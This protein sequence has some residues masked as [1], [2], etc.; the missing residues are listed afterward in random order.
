MKAVASLPPEELHR[1]HELFEDHLAE[2][3]RQRLAE[4]AERKARGIGYRS[5]VEP[6]LPVL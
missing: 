1:F 5:P 2:I 6:T 3:W 4:M